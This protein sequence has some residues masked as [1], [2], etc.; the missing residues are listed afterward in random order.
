MGWAAN[1]GVAAAITKGIGFGYSEY[2]RS[3][4]NP[5]TGE[6]KLDLEDLKKNFM[7]FFEKFKNMEGN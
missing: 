4:V 1:G 5:E 7:K 2:L 6:V 3:N